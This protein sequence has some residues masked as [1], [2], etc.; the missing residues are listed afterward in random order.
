MNHLDINLVLYFENK[1]KQ[2]CLWVHDLKDWLFL[3][4]NKKESE[5]LSCH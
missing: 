1:E 5:G 3:H 4:S 2:M